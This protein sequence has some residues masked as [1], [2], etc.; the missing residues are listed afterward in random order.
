M[1][2]K[3]IVIGLGITGYSVVQYFREKN[4][5]VL[6]MDTRLS[7]PKLADLI[8]YYPEVNYILGDL[9]KEPLEGAERIVLSPG[10]GLQHPALQWAIEHGIPIQGDIQIFLDQ[11][12]VPVV[13]I[14]GTNAKSTVTTLVGLMAEQAGKKVGVGGNLGT[15]VLDLLRRQADADCFVLELSSFQLETMQDF[16]LA[17]ACIL[18]ITPDHLDRYDSFSEYCQAKWRIYSGAK[19]KVANLDDHNTF[20]ILNEAERQ[21]CHYFTVVSPTNQ[22]FGIAEH[23]GKSYLMKGQQILMGV[24]ELPFVGLHNQSN[25]LAALA[26]GEGLQLPMHSMLQTLRSFKGLPH[27][28][29]WVRE[30]N[31]VRWYNDS[32]GTNVGATQ[33][34]VEGLGAVI[35]GKIILI[36]GGVSKQADFSP[37]IPLLKKYVSFAILIGEATSDLQRVCEGNVDYALANT[38]EEIIQIAYGKAKAGDAVLLSPACASFDW[39]KDYAHRGEV[40]VNAVNQ[41]SN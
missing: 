5:P 14:T 41:L 28:C 3:I 25:A 19:Y 12:K 16:S 32:K 9:T 6:V 21:N 37:L 4:I 30:V 17:V 39:F 31:G 36:L 20:A 22:A 18:N 26:I 7:P 40:F 23:Q 38:M 24:D 2:E 27:R 8:Q 11:V 33:A 34:A 13:G 1:K 15:P 10:I 29:Q 35:P